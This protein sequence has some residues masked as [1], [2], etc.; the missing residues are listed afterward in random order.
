LD[1]LPPP[2]HYP[3]V[4]NVPATTNMQ[5]MAAAAAAAAAAGQVLA[6]GA[7]KPDEEFSVILADVRKTCYSS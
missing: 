2:Q 4:Q 1:G 5:S 3:D 7:G 6:A